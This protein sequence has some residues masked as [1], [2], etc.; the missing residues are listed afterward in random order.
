VT[1]RITVTGLGSVS[2][3]GLGREALREALRTPAPKL[4][5]VD[6]SGGHHRTRGARMAV[7]VGS[8]PL[9]R[10]VSPAAARRMSASSRWAVAAARLA[11][12]EAGLS[13]DKLPART[14]VY[15]GT[16]FGAVRVSEEI[17]GQILG[18]GPEAASPALFPETVANAPAAQVAIAC[19]ARGPSVA[20]TQSEASALLAVGMAARDLAGGRVDLALAGAVDE[21]GPLAHAIL[22][23][24]RALARP[25]TDGR[26][27]ARPF[28][29]GRDGFLMGEGACVLAL[30][31]EDTVRGRGAKARLHVDAAPSGFDPSARAGS[32]GRGHDALAATLRGALEAQ[33]AFERIDRIVSGASGSLAGDR[34]EGRVLRAAWGERALPPVLAP[35]A[36]AGEYGG[37]FLAAA[38]L[39]AEAAE[40]GPTP[41]FRTPDPDCAVVPYV[42]GPLPAPRLTLASSLAAGGAAAW[43]LFGRE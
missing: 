22:D 38:V 42:G 14:G 25:D 26:E 1:P 20:V 36:L 8:L 19:G 6:R 24:F 13:F 12:E 16:A 21:T 43:V 28:D 39:A 15:I 18:P 30:E 33:G 3:Y 34:L 29:A 37:S 4:A 23:R 31:R 5:E 27:Q 10:L 2:A 9:G 7:L 35:K 11:C 32:W 40:F 41:G 17:V